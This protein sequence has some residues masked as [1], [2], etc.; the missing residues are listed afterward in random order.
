MPAKM[1]LYTHHF[2]IRGFDHVER[3]CIEE[4]LKGFVQYNKHVDRSGRVHVEKVCVYAASNKGR[5]EYRIHRNALPEFKKFWQER[6]MAEIPCEEMSLYEPKLT[7][8]EMKEIPLRDTQVPVYE[9][10]INDPTRGKLVPLQTGQG[11]TFTF[12]KAITTLG[13]LSCAIMRPKYIENWLLALYGKDRVT[14]IDPD[15]VLVVAGSAQLIAL[16]E[17]A[18]ND[19]L[20]AKFILISN[21]TIQNYIKHYEEDGDISDIYGCNPV[22]LWKTLGV[23]VVGRDEGH[24][25]FHF[26]FKL[27]CYMHAPMSITL[28]ATFNAEDIFLNKMQSIQ[29]PPFARAPRVKWI[30]I[31]DVLGLAYS[32]R[33]PTKIQY[34]LRGRKDYNHSRFEET[35]MRSRKGFAAW[36]DLIADVV[37]REYIRLYKP[38]M[39]YM[40][41]VTRVDMAQAVTEHLQSLNPTLAVRK[42]S[43]GEVLEEIVKADI[44]VTTVMSGSTAIDVPGLIGALL[45]T[46]VGAKETN[47]QLL[48][49]VRYPK[50]FPEI[51]P[52]F[53]YL[54]C[55]TIS[56]S[57]SYHQSKLKYFSGLVHSHS[58]RHSGVTLQ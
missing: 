21:R 51:R 28:S 58:S 31:C 52:R 13:V 22:D 29:F 5:T 26:N 24:L 2:V 27:D 55:D 45:T 32:L 15:D 39:R 19:N 44:V 14:N 6:R 25:D 46:S 41:F 1:F 18:M 49:R 11:K 3:S 30:K 56:P 17:D 9:Y 36:L 50:D 23:G 54:Y 33:Y 53:V 42:L 8:F 7:T 43:Q 37:D 12:L 34:N 4:Y 16:I 35:L 48:G 38:G 40:V 57:M 47:I 20:S 10:L